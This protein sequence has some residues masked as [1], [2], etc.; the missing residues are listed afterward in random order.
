MN[1]ETTAV[2]DLL[3][4]FVATPHSSEFCIG[5]SRAMLETNDPTLANA[6]RKAL[7]TCDGDPTGGDSN[8]KLVRDEQAPCGGLNVAVL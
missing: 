2:P 8:W 1:T 6:V 7:A 3:H 4:R 5:S